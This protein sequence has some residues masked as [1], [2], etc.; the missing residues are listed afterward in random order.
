MGNFL[1][2]KHSLSC[3]YMIP[4]ACKYEYM[5]VDPTNFIPLFFKSFEISS[6]NFDVVLSLSYTSGNFSL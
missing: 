4:I 2:K 3:E 6:D 5:I 1:Y